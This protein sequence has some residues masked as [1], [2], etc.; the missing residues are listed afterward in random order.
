MKKIDLGEPLGRIGFAAGKGCAG[1]LPS[2]YLA[3]VAQGPEFYRGVS[4]A[5]YVNYQLRQQF[6]LSEMIVSMEAIIAKALEDGA[7]PYQKGSHPVPLLL[8]DTIRESS[9]ILTGTE[10]G[11]LFKPLN[12]GVSRFI[13]SAMMW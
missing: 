7:M 6:D 13:Y 1:C 2:G 5:L 4:V 10:A 3:V 9:F 8:G 12:I 11:V